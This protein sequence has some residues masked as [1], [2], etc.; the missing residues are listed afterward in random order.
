VVGAIVAHISVNSLNEYYDF[1]S[2]LDSRTIRT[3]FSG[4][5]GT[6]QERPEMAKAGLII[7]LVSLGITA[8]IGL[9]FLLQ[10]GWGLLPVGILGV[11]TIVAYTPLITR[12]P[13]LCL[14]APGF[15]FGSLMVLGAHF[16]LTGEYS[17][18][19]FIASLVPFFLVNDL[20]LLNQFPDAEADATV[21]RKHLPIAAGKRTSSIVYGLFL[22]GT[23]LS[24][25]VGVALQLLPAWALLGLATLLL[26]VPLAIGVYRNHDSA[27][28]L[29]P[30]LGQ[31]VIL[32]IVTPVLLAIGLLIA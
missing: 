6:L 26:A 3:P 12:S 22:L 2:G 25:V 13:L 7:G 31:N 10:V 30:F 8:L 19:A 21:G 1:K 18:T 16:C 29:M 4:G 23:Y 32:N 11:V 9:Y 20:L 17:W 28:G 15:G 24:I 5:S 14:V 27:E